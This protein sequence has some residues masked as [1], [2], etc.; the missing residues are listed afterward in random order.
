MYSPPPS[1]TGTSR[2][3]IFI[4]NAPILAICGLFFIFFIIAATIVL[5][6]IPLYLETKDAPSVGRSPTYY[7]TMEPGETLPEG[8]LDAQ[9]IKNLNDALDTTLNLQKGS[10]N[11]ITATVAAGSKKRKRR[12]LTRKRQRRATTKLF[13]TFNFNIKVCPRCG[14]QG[15]L[16][17]ITRIT[18]AVRIW[19]I[20]IYGILRGPFS[21]TFTI[22]ISYIEIPI[23]TTSALPVTT[24]TPTPKLVG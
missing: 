24:V 22:T 10:V 11:I 1:S 14:R 5:A 9:S 4:A 7:A 12:A 19:I 15:F 23:P 17:T 20:D 8:T 6:L 2:R 16:K 18:I 13:C 3:N 21:V